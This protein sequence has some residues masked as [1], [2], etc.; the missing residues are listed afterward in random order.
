M[1]RNHRHHKTSDSR[2]IARTEAV[3]LPAEGA[4]TAD[5]STVVLQKFQPE[6]PVYQ[7][8]LRRWDPLVDR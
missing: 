2:R 8:Y 3:A 4:T 6:K 5:S 1:S 7:G